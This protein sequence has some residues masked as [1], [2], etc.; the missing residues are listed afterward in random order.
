MLGLFYS[1]GINE[2]LLSKNAFNY[3][4][5]ADLHRELNENFSFIVLSDT[6]ITKTNSNG[7]ERLA[8][9]I[10]ENGD[11]FVVITGD[12]TQS[13]KQAELESFIQIAN[14]FNVPCYPIIGNHDVYF[15]NWDVW[16]KM[17]GS[18]LYRVDLGTATLIM[19]DSANASFGNEQL[20]WL[21]SQ[22]RTT[23]KNTF[24]FTHANLF[25]SGGGELQQFSDIRERARLMSLLNGKCTAFFSGHSHEYITKN[26]EGTSYLTLKDFINDGAYCRVTVSPNGV[27]YEIK[28]L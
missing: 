1:T 14:S 8:E 27:T 28:S 7:L 11:S 20:N 26:T 13:G 10:A 16:N 4:D 19:L 5:D 3:L 18:T 12:I 21:E 17:I 9:I 15:G 22:L 24:V 2:R 6:H 25:T 23:E